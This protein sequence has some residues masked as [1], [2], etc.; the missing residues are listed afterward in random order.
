MLAMTQNEIEE[1]ILRQA[2]AFSANRHVNLDDYIYKDLK[3]GG[4]DAVEFYSDIEKMF[5][6]DLRP[7]T[8]TTV[9]AV[10][11]W[12]RKPR[13][14]AVPRDFPLREIVSFVMAR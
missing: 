3:I 2:R 1:Y 11:S 5:D 10:G 7:I 9:E 13:H 6:I 14:K 12:F 4:G 8:E